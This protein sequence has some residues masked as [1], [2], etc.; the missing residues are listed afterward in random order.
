MKGNIDDDAWVSCT[1]DLCKGVPSTVIREWMKEVILNESQNKLLNPPKSS[2]HTGSSKRPVEVEVEVTPEP[3]LK[4]KK[5]KQS[6]D[7]NLKDPAAT[8]E[9][10]TRKSGRQTCPPNGFL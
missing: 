1:S 7:V 3:S 5:V 9:K 4:R 6:K 10:P 8:L 2:T